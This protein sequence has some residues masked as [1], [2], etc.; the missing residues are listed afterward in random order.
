MMEILDLGGRKVINHNYDILF[1]S[2][3]LMLHVSAVFTTSS[4]AVRM[5]QEGSFCKIH[6][7]RN[8]KGMKSHM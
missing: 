2:R 7:L 8:N 1:I 4:S 5:I 6:K 3:Y